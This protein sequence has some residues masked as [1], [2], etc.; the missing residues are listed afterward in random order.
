MIIKTADG[1]ELLVHEPREKYGYYWI[2]KGW[3]WDSGDEAVYYDI[4]TGEDDD[5]S[6]VIKYG[7][8]A[9]GHPSYYYIQYLPIED[10]EMKTDKGDK[11]LKSISN[12]Y[13]TDIN[14]D[15][16]DV[17]VAF[18]VT[19]PATAHAIKK[20]LCAGQRGHKSYT[21]D[22]NEAVVSLERAKQLNH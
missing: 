3:G 2:H 20:I 7:R 22:I 15:V 12:K 13:G 16:Y 4:I 19:C 8:K 11:Y 1:E 5:W 17:L 6:K 10:K 21:E 18:E 14:V 9:N